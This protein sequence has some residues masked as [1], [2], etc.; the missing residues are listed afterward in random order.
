MVS[1][2]LCG[3]CMRADLQ[4]RAVF[5]LAGIPGVEIFGSGSAIARFR[6]V[7]AR[8]RSRSRFHSRFHSRFR[9]CLRLLKLL[10]RG[11]SAQQ[12]ACQGCAA[13][14]EALRASSCTCEKVAVDSVRRN[15]R[16]LTCVVQS[17]THQSRSLPALSCMV[18]I[19]SGLGGA[20]MLP[21]ANVSC[22]S[23]SSCRHSCSSA[24]LPRRCKCRFTW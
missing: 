21:S 5:P 22:I 9:S 17:D 4:T 23:A 16:P 8:P 3:R 12:G 1:R 6:P 15:I 20:Y 2:G 19:L 18:R 11:E 14:L 7:R 10:P 13:S 24:G